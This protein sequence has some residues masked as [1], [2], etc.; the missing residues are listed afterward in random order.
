MNRGQWQGLK[1]L[2]LSQMTAM[3]PYPCPTV[4]DVKT[5][6]DLCTVP[7][8]LSFPSSASSSERL[9]PIAPAVGGAS[10]AGCLINTWG[11][12]GHDREWSAAAFTLTL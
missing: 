8:A 12:V 10:H 11:H 6:T 7:K 3:G 2:E 5:R 4:C 9:L 1:K